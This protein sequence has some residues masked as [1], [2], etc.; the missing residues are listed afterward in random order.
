MKSALETFARIVAPF[1]PHFAEELWHIL[2]PDAAETV[3]VFDQPWPSYDPQALIRQ[4]VTLVVQING[5]LRDRMEVPADVT[6]DQAVALAQ[7]SERLK[8]YL[9]GQ[10]IRKV[11]FVPGK[12]LNVVVS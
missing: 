9:A 8:P 2:K 5:K 12:L 1:A 10:H 4:T 6:E 7:A 11:I 3:S